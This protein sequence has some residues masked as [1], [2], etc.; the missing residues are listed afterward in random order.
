MQGTL[1]IV[2][3]PI[4]NLSD[5]T[6][7]AVETLKSVDI[8]AA[9]DTRIT[10]V[11]LAHYG[12][13]TK[14]I[15]Y[16]SYSKQSREASIVDALKEGKNVALVS[17]NGT[18]TISDPGFSLVRSALEAGASV[19]PIPGPCAMT[20]ALSAGG[21][22]TDTFRFYGFLAVK[23]GR[24]GKQI[25]EIVDSGITC[26]VYESPHRIQK[27]L[28]EISAAAPECPVVVAREI[29]KK[30]EEFFRG[31]AAEAAAY[32]HEREPRGEFVILINSSLANKLKSR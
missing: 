12:I 16:H 24:R 32:F 3:T 17:D 6:Y 23:P 21:M 2:A 25:R 10:A 8:I 31:T 4:G 30:F 22:P 7:R 27:L 15:S 26:V 28:D 9:E 1:Y 19:V 11:L 29:T 13:T 14:T 20:A 5:I 18:P